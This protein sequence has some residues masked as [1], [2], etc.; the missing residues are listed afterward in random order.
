[1]GIHDI[2]SR[3]VGRRA[4]SVIVPDTPSTRRLSNAT[5]PAQ[6]TANKPNLFQSYYGGIKAADGVYEIYYVGIID[7]LQVSV[8]T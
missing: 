3:K 5:A 1:M 2:R 4:S 7:I 8:Y 6:D